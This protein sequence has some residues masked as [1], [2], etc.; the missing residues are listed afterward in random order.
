ME[1][2]GNLHLLRMGNQILVYSCLGKVIARLI[3]VAILYD[4]Q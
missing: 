1:N 3:T 2:Q 4:I